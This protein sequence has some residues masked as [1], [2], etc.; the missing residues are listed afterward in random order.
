MPILILGG[1]C[2]AWTTYEL[3]RLA[4]L[5]SPPRIRAWDEQGRPIKVEV[6]S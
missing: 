5:A 3:A 2:V 4:L 6:V 1:L